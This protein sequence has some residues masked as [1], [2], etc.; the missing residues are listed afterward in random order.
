MFLNN[1]F[2]VSSFEFD[3][4]G[5]SRTED[6]RLWVGPRRHD[7]NYWFRALFPLI[8]AAI[9]A[10]FLI[11]TCVSAGTA[12]HLM[13]FGVNPVLEYSFQLG[14]LI[15][16]LVVV[17]NITRNEY[18]ISTY[19]SAK[20]HAERLFRLWNLAFVGS[21]ALGFLT[22][23]GG[24]YSRGTIVLFYFFGF[25]VLVL[26]RMTLTRIVKVNSKRGNVSVRRTFLAGTKAELQAFADRYQPWNVGFEIVGVA[27]IQTAEDG[28]LDDR[29]TADLDRAVA[30]A[31]TY[32]ID[33]VFV[34]APWQ[35]SDLIGACVDAF[36]NLP[37]AIHLGPE[38]V[39]DRFEDIRVTKIGP[40][41]SLT[42]VRR[43]LSVGEQVEKRLFDIVLAALALFVLMPLLPVISL[44]I[45]LDSRGPVFF[46]QTRFGFNQVPFQIV[47][48]R[49][50]RTLDDGAIIKQARRNDPRVTRVGKWLRRL[51]LDELPQLWNVLAGHMSLVGPRPHALA[52]DH[53]Y[54]RKIATYARRHNVKPGITGW[55]QVNGFRGETT[56]D[57]IMSK[58]VECD[59]FYI[60][61]WSI[62][63]DLRILA[64]TVLSS[65]ARNNAF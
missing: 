4:A 19:L 21:A 60:D 53:E 18:Q 59:L 54:V 17:S 40:I 35:R 12:Y 39:F 7:R 63:M 44:L 2:D 49:T 32:R 20:G 62:W 47:K 57:D 50:M 26:V 65:K 34:I 37:A 36:L 29:S 16:I 5:G 28:S 55:A 41:S 64:L 45:K 22:K 58:R 38:R 33:D 9:D 6:G 46:K 13:R 48:F 23:T 8:A 51:S 42:L 14:S 31:R 61:N 56:S 52:H 3:D 11:L 1:N 25:I 24:F 15:A 43:P 27:T 30:I 10:I